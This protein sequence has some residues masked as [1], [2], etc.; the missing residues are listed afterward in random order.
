MF[1][2]RAVLALFLSLGTQTKSFSVPPNTNHASG[3]F[4][5]TTLSNSW[6]ADNR[7]N[8]NIYST[9]AADISDLPLPP[10]K[11]GPLRR[12]RDM[13]S[14]LKGPDRFL[15]RRSKELDSQIFQYYDFFR[16]TTAIGGQDAIQEFST[17]REAEATVIHSALP[18]TFQELHTE[19]GALNL[20]SKDVTFKQSRSLFTDVLAGLTALE[21]HTKIMEP[22]IDEYV[23]DLAERVRK[24]PEEEF[25]IVP[26]VIDLC[27]QAFAITF[28]GQN[29][30]EA[31]LNLFKT[32]NAGLLGLSKKGKAFK[33]GAQ[34][35]ISIKE[36]TKDRLKVLEDPSMSIEAPGKFYA[37]SISHREGFENEDRRVTTTL[38]F[39]WGAYIECAALMTCALS[40]M[41][42]Q[43]IETDLVAAEYA[44]AKESNFEE[45]EYKFWQKMEYTT[46]ILRESLRLEPPGNGVGR[47]GE[48]DFALGGYRIPKG[49]PVMMV[50]S[51]GNGDPNLF[52]NP[53]V[54][55]PLR[56]ENTKDAESK[57]PL[58]GT[59]LKL[60][61]GSWL[62]GGGGAHKCPGVPLAELVSN[63][64]LAKM[65]EKFASIRFSG[66]GLDKD[67]AINYDMIPIKICPDDFGLYFELNDAPVVSS[68]KKEA[69]IEVEN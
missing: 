42:K 4:Y 53:E 50:P 11:G 45:S 13:A 23:N 8:T 41:I 7:S 31:E 24:N 63:M 62:P 38:L 40:Q 64:F 20:N 57:C 10:R 61:P 9:N 25:F 17:K 52:K 46:G 21:Y 33:E 47:Y 22:I 28:S 39:I 69:S 12:F 68:V 5:T 26:E 65:S 37:N 49:V 66:S 16:L 14:Y 6:R 43:D 59:A 30:N 27:L 3:S 15:A 67:G 36:I 1:H 32:Y 54:F 34:A 48:K 18:P 56:W 44:A 29:L 2:T 55:E 35:L 60:G 51:I 58:H 19:W